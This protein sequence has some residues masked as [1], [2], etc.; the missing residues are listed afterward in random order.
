M[1]QYEDRGL[2][3]LLQM[4]DD[5]AWHLFAIKI[6]NGNRDRVKDMML[7]FHNVKTDIYYS[8]LSHHQHKSLPVTESVRKQMLQ[9]PLYSGLY[10]RRTKKVMEALID[11]VS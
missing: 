11:V 3:K 5:H 9:R 2:I 6:I 4:T 8:I 7:K 10:R 1:Q